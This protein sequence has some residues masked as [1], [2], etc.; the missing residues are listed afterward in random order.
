MEL[1]LR[2][3]EVEPCKCKKMY[4]QDAQLEV[5]FVHGIYSYV[6][7]NRWHKL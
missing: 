1:T 6:W 5:C 3:R 2:R 7:E 4:D